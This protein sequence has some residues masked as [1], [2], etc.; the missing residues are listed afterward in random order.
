MFKKE[1]KIKRFDFILII[2]TI[3]LCI[4]G[5]IVINSA[6][7]SKAVGSQP[8]LKTQIT[9]F[10]LGMVAL[11]VLLFIDY[12]IYKN[13]ENDRRT[14]RQPITSGRINRTV[15]MEKLILTYKGMDSSDR[16]VYEDKE[17]NL[18][19]DIDP[20]KDWEPDLCTS[21]QNAFDGEPDIN[22]KYIKNFQDADIE[23]VPERITW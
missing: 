9:A 18:W 14:G 4:Y 1:S 8:F 11:F 5:F 2:T 17:G 6:T 12:D 16:P 19:K 21:C 3:L 7:M 10:V 15:N 22:M 23:F 20:R 13:Y